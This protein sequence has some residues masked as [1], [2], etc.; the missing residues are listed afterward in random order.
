MSSKTL[1]KLLKI[2]K[3][4]ERVIFGL[5]RTGVQKGRKPNVYGAWRDKKGKKKGVKS[6][7]GEGGVLQNF[8]FREGDHR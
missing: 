4:A 3:L 7:I 1:H 6:G 5:C 8:D 2:S